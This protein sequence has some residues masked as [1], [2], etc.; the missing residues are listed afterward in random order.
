M[1]DSISIALLGNCTTEFIG[2]ALQDRCRQNELEPKIYNSPFN[3]YNQQILNPESGLYTANPDLIILLLEGEQLFPEWYN[4]K[5]LQANKEEK[6]SMIDAIHKQIVDIIEFLHSHISS[7]IIINNFRVPYH[8]PLGILD[9]KSDPGLKRMIT[10]MNLRLEEWSAAHEY[11]NV[12]D[13]NGLCA[14]MGNM[15]AMDKKLFYSTGNPMSIPFTQLLAQEY[16]RYILAIKSR[17]KKCLVLDLDN[18]LWGGIC[19]EDGISGIKLDLKGPGRSFYDFQKELLNLYGKGVLLAVNSKNNREDALDIIEN[20]PYML[21]RSRHFSAMRINWQDKVRNLKEIA[22]EL[23]IGLDSMVFFDDSP[24]ERDYVKTVLPC[25]TVVDVPEDTVKYSDTLRS[26]A[27]FESFGITTEDIKRSELYELNKKRN[28][29]KVQFD[30][31]EAYLIS[32]ETKITV[33]YAN[34]F[35]IPR[36]VQLLQKTNQFNVTTIRYCR[37]EIENMAASDKYHIL[38]C[39]SSDKFGDSGMVGVCIAVV[40]NGEALIDSFLLSCR[41]LGRNIEQ[42]FLNA[43]VSILRQKGISCIYSKFIKTEKNQA[44]VNFYPGAG[45]IK[46]SDKGNETLFI[47]PEQTELKQLSHISTTIILQE[48]N[49]G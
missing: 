37:Q 42:A 2:F 6:E 4:L 16:I 10:M 17:T 48:G 27:I 3:Q 18:T 1:P 31:L 19:A 49:N 47:L 44:N 28:D 21:L 29:S 38:Q 41:A 34:E 11:V 46:V 23:N 24:M 9:N 45:F 13:Y 26:L 35:T 15:K 36:I 39:S 14:H 43:V 25:V 7:R 12:F 40:E 5:T 32:L 30:S 33:E 20:H 8:S 22:N